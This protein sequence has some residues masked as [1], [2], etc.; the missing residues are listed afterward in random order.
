MTN[1]KVHDICSQVTQPQPLNSLL[2]PIGT[3]SCLHSNLTYGNFLILE[4]SSLV[5]CLCS[6]LIA[7][8]HIF[9]MLRSNLFCSFW[10][11]LNSCEITLVLLFI[12]VFVEVDSCFNGGNFSFLNIEGV[13]SLFDTTRSPLLPSYHPLLPITF[14]PHKHK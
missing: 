12:N 4:Y 14:L 11:I 7:Y 5:M 13:Y 2:K 10:S 6:L 8:V 1:A 9:A 3:I